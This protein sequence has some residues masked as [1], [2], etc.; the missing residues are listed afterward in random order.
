[1]K[2]LILSLGVVLMA[3]S[4]SFAQN[5]NKTKAPKAQAVQLA[6]AP[7]T[8][9]Q[10]A[11]AANA[12]SHDG[13]D[14]GPAATTTAPASNLKPEDVVFATETH[15]FGT[16]PEGPAAEYEFSF[17]NKG[18]EPLIIQQVHASCGCTTPSYSKE[19]VLPGQ[20]GK[21]KASYST[22]GRPNAFTKTITVVSNAG[23]KMLTIKGE[24]EKAPESSVPTNTSM[25][26]TN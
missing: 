11:A 25:I 24:V 2:K 5:K 8:P 20:T 12:A 22:V 1:M 26:K 7:E 13:H 10:K 14:H 23:T 4:V 9:E 3:A 19:P 15:D 6:V 16:I 17:T 18:K 21:V